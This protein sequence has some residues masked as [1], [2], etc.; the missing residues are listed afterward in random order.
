ML[1][2]PEPP[3]IIYC[4]DSES[5]LALACCLGGL[6]LQ[7]VA[8]HSSGSRTVRDRN[9]P[10]NEHGLSVTLGSIT[11]HDGQMLETS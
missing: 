11:A 3:L 7:R 8:L 1:L 5:A 4:P 2:W 10:V 6:L 9:M